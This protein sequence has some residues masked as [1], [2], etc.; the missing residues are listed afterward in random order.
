MHLTRWP[1]PPS[2]TAVCPGRGLSIQISAR[3]NLVRVV[4]SPRPDDQLV[5][6]VGMTRG[7]DQVDR[8]RRPP[9]GAPPWQSLPH[10]ARPMFIRTSHHTSRKTLRAK[11]RGPQS[12]VDMDRVRRRG[13]HRF[14]NTSLY[15]S[16]T[17]RGSNS[18]ALNWPSYASRRR[19]PSEPSSLSSESISASPSLTAN[20]MPL[21]SS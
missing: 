4:R 16:A 21:L 13:G 9:A 3:G 12:T 7:P 1:T 15:S 6:V 17:L 19:R 14:R 10:S 5:A 11:Q 18:R 2:R 8:R 20:L